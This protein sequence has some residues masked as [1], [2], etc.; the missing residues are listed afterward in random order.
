MIQWPVHALLSAQRLPASGLG[1]M[2]TSTRLRMTQDAPRCAA[3]ARC[4][5]GVIRARNSCGARV[6]TRIALAATVATIRHIAQ[7]ANMSSAASVI[8]SLAVAITA[9]ASGAHFGLWSEGR[10]ISPACAAAH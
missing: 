6:P 5:S 8:A 10:V 3:Q 1:A 4:S 7:R 9:S 2:Q